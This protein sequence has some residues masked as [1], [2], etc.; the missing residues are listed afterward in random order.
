MI[1]HPATGFHVASVHSIDVSAIASLRSSG[2]QNYTITACDFP[3]DVPTSSLASTAGSFEPR[4]I[5]HRFI[6]GVLAG[7]V[8]C[9]RVRLYTGDGLAINMVYEEFAL[10]HNSHLEGDRADVGGLF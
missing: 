6:F 2:S 9:A 1:E 10:A 5:S 8:P 3:I 4:L 7:L